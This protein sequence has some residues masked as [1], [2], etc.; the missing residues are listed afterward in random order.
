M[1]EKLKIN[2]DFF[3]TFFGLE[4]FRA[5]R[6]LFIFSPFS[7]KNFFYND[8]KILAKRKIKVLSGLFFIHCNENRI[9]KTIQI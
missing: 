9:K 7:K 2:F 3:I 8:F 6:L 4:F 1:K 5:Q